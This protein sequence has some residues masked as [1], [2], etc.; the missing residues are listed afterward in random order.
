M[1]PDTVKGFDL[2]RDC[3]AIVGGIPEDKFNLGTYGEATPCGTIACAAGWLCMHPVFPV[4]DDAAARWENL[5]L[6]DRMVRR[7]SAF[8]RWISGHFTGMAHYDVDDLF[9]GNT[10]AGTR[11]DR[12]A[13]AKGLTHRAL[14][15]YRVA[16][17]LADRAQPVREDF[18]SE[19]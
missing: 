6:S 8:R 4:S 13:Q 5:P 7:G 16:R 2:L 12:E 18:W 9:S 11:Y 3:A 14:F 1:N 19:L 10:E 17:F 15:R